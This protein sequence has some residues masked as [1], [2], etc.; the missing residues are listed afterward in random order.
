[1]SLCVAW[2]W[3]DEVSFASDSCIAQADKAVSH[4]GI[5]LATIPVRVL[6]AQSAQSR[7]TDERFNA[8]YGLAFS[9][10]YLAG[11]V[12]REVLSEILSHLQFVAATELMTIER[13]MRIVHVF[14][15]FYTN[16]LRESFQFGHDLDFLIGGRCPATGHVKVF[17]HI[18][19]E[20][21]VPKYAEVLT[22]GAFAYSA[23]GAGEERFRELIEED[24]RHP[25]CEVH[26]AVFRR[27][28]D[29]IRDPNIPSVGGSIQTGAFEHGEFKLF[30]VMEHDLSGDVPR[31]LPS[32]RGVVID[33]I[34]QGQNLDDFYIH[35]TF[36]APF[37]SDLE[38]LFDQDN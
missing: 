36:K 8:N 25:P 15:G 2:R 19:S 34:Y 5:K 24:L 37:E 21:S 17:E 30:G 29:V 9:G 7:Q 11:Y 27:L 26:F 18:A 10:S 32:V 3:R 6:S 12:I 16:R 13:I 28:R 1:M 4:L 22:S 35:Y 14:H 33:E 38:K 20:D 31:A 23:I